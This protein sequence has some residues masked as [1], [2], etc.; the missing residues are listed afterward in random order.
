MDGRSSSSSA[1]ERA[2]FSSF[3]DRSLT[4]IAEQV[5]D[6]AAILARRLGELRVRLV[7]DGERVQVRRRDD[8]LVVLGDAPDCSTEFATD[9]ATLVDLV[10]GRSTFLDDLLADRIALHGPVDELIAFHDALHVYLH[11]A[12]RSPALP[13]LL[14]EFVAVPAKGEIDG[15]E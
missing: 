12:V 1:P 10:E 2:P 13:A 8:R 5:P 11:G 14:D 4:A 6:L 9:R 7:I 15:E 3:L